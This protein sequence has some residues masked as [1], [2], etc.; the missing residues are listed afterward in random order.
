MAL[1]D[2]FPARFGGRGIVG[3]ASENRGFLTRP[4]A[5]HFDASVDVTSARKQ[6]AF[7]RV[8]GGD[9]RAA[10]NSTVR[11][12]SRVSRCIVPIVSRSVATKPVQSEVALYSN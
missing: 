1:S 6:D 10:A 11:Q 3:P 2:W 12:P 7:G 9:R 8:G 5:C 4:L